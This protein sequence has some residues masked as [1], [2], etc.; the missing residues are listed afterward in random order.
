MGQ[1]LFK[2]ISYISK[3]L[4]IMLVRCAEPGNLIFQSYLYFHLLSWQ[5]QL[6]CY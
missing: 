5:L 4:K 1:L 3:L 2:S 6:L